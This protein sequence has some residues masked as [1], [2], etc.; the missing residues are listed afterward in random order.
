MDPSRHSTRERDDRRPAALPVADDA[1]TAERFGAGDG[2]T[3]RGGA[4][5]RRLYQVRAYGEA[6]KREELERALE[7]LG[8]REDLTDEER[9]VVAEMADSIVEEL[10]YEPVRQLAEVEPDSLD[11]VVDLLG[12]D[13]GDEPG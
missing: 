7:R 5:T 11:R 8:P 2:R 10:L 1:E 6:I 4:A 12:A 13:D 9:E 3:E